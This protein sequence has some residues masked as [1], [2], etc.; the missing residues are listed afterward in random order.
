M[1]VHVT[2]DLARRASEFCNDIQ[3]VAVGGK[4][5]TRDISTTAPVLVAIRDAFAKH[6]RDMNAS[7]G[8]TMDGKLTKE[9]EG[10]GK[11]DVNR[12]CV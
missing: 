10:S 8:H 5:E 1:N 7:H 12:R 11:V 3:W 9:G 4:R 2:Q 6:V